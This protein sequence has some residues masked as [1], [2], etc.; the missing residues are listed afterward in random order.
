MARLVIPSINS[1]T[2]APVTSWTVLYSCYSPWN[3][4]SCP[5]GSTTSS[6]SST[7]SSITGLKKGSS[8]TFVVFGVNSGGVA[9]TVIVGLNAVVMTTTSVNLIWTPPTDNGGQ[10]ISHY[11]IQYGILDGNNLINITNTTTMATQILLSGLT[12]NSWYLFSVAAHNGFAVGDVSSK[13]TLLLGY[14]IKPASVLPSVI[15]DTYVNITW[16]LENPA[17]FIDYFN[18]SYRLESSQTWNVAAPILSNGILNYLLTGL[19]PNTTY[20]V[21]VATKNG[22]QDPSNYTTVTFTT[23]GLFVLHEMWVGLWNEVTSC[24]LIVA[25]ISTVT[26]FL[27]A[28]ANTVYSLQKRNNASGEIGYT[29]DQEQD[30]AMEVNCAYAT[31]RF[32]ENNEIETY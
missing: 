12:E 31:F 3:P 23:A 5:S 9:P 24:P 30:T 11:V 19:S 28:F 7:S 21:G 29:G 26:T 8:Y 22:L 27:V 18:L 1:S 6:S 25:I 2:T 17:G 4:S 10:N 16:L 15:M 14:P 20:V 13:V 32:N